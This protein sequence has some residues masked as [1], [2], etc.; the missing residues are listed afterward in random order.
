MEAGIPSIT[1]WGS[2]RFFEIVWGWNIWSSSDV[3][4]LFFNE[5][6][7]SHLH[8]GQFSLWLT[9]SNIAHNAH[10]YCSASGI[11]SLLQ[12][13]FMRLMQQCFSPSVCPVSSPP[14]LYTLLKQIRFQSFNCHTNTTINTVVPVSH[15]SLT[16]QAESLL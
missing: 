16:R 11:K 15:K 6:S 3:Q 8:I 12:F 14:H 7:F 13:Y 9:I 4:D 5:L 10:A 2:L 1:S